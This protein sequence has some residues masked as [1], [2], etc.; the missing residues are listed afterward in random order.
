MTIF[1]LA[2]LIKT[3]FPHPVPSSIAVAIAILYNLERTPGEGVEV[4]RNP[5]NVT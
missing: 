2:T 1:W 5:R 4:G 3:Y